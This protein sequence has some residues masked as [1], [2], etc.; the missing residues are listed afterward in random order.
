MENIGNIKNK[1]PENLSGIHI[2]FVGI[3]GTGMAALVEILYHNGAIITGSDVEE[4]FYTDEILESLG[5]KVK[6]FSKENITDKIEYVIYSS[7][8]KLDKNPD[9]IAAVEKNLPCLLYTQALGSYSSLYYSCGVCGVHGKTSTTG[10]VGTILKELD[11]PTQTLVGSK[12]KSFGDT[13]TFTSD[14]FKQL[15]S[16]AENRKNSVFVAETCEYQRHFMEFFPKNIILTSVE[17]DHQDYYPTYESI[18][19]AFVDYI[20]K[21]PI[22]GNLIFCSDDKGAVE[23][24]LIAKSKRGDINFIPYGI[25]DF[26]CDLGFNANPKNVRVKALSE[27]CL[28]RTYFCDS[29]NFKISLGKIDDGKQYFKI[30]CFGD[31]DFKLSVP[32][33]HEVLDAVAAIALVCKIIEHFGKNPIDFVDTIAL[34]VEKF[35]G[36]KRR[37]EI[38]S[39]L[40]IN[41]NDVIVIDDYGHHPTAVKTTL[42]GFRNFYKN[43]KII[44]DFMS[45]TYSRTQSLLKEFSQSF[46][47]ADMVIL[48]KIYSS[49]RENPSDFEI[50][51][52]TL[53]DEV[54]KNFKNKEN[55]FYFEEVLDA[56]DFVLSEL[57]KPLPEDKNGYLF[58]TMGA[59]DNWKLGK[60]IGN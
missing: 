38:V 1:L 24:A 25:N 7:A 11:L 53:F 6:T 31:K 50:T 30:K 35:S 14:A 43:R 27:A 49:A 37:S 23:T 22:G 47:S 41:N 3:K 44:V 26:S 36:G 46:G 20:C 9:L 57:A 54:Q 4:R 16:N 21:L 2:H 18:R 32:G 59:G 10:L 42:E 45:H 12:I 19:D 40:K 58:V 33:I 60:E 5:I 15:D 56:K 52:K 17:S 55:V 34:G 8:Y 51:G 39:R 48:H 13:C 28:D 29:F